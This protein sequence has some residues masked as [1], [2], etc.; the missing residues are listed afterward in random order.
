MTRFVRS[1]IVFALSLA[2][3]GSM[4]VAPTIV[5]AATPDAD[6]KTGLIPKPTGKCPEDYLKPGTMTP[7]GTPCKNGVERDYRLDDIKALLAILGNFMLGISGAI[8][9]FMFVLGGFFWIASAG[10]PKMVDKGKEMISGAV[11]GLIIL[12]TAYTLVIFAVRTLVG[13]GADEYLPGSQAPT[14]NGTAGAGGSTPVMATKKGI[15]DMLP[16]G[17]DTTKVCGAVKGQ[18]VPKDSCKTA[19]LILNACAGGSAQECC[20]PTTQPAQKTSCGKVGGTCVDK[21]KGKCSGALVK[22]LC[23]GSGQGNNIEC[24]FNLK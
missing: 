23:D 20:M 6:N 4:V 5:S 15:I 18:C 19:S 24:C 9:L 1:F 17:Y 8:V 10:N 3:V 11:I 22:G 2:F 21:T 16:S 14:G 13:T 12:F 7:I